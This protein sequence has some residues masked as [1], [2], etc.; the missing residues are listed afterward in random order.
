[1][2]YIILDQDDS[3]SK[4]IAKNWPDIRIINDTSNFWH[5]AYAWKLH[6]EELNTK[7]TGDWHKENIVG[8]GP[9]MDMY[10]LM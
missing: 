5:F 6:S 3:Y 4:Y 8:H 7:L 10:A 1:V 9:L 2:L